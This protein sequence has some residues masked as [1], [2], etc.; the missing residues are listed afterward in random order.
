M[1]V[2]SRCHR[3]LCLHN[4]GIGGNLRAGGTVERIGKQ[5]TAQTL[6][7]ERLIYGQAAH[8]NSW[9]GRIARQLLADANV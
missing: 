6:P 9:H 4:K 5:S 8:A 2:E 7:F 1:P 3:V